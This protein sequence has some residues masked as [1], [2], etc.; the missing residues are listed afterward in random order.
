MN[1]SC[2]HIRALICPRPGSY[3]LLWDRLFAPQEHVNII[4]ADVYS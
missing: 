4:P 1:A 3:L 2:V